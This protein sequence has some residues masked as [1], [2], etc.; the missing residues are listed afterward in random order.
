MSSSK[1][2]TLLTY[3]ATIFLDTQQEF[4]K[5]AKLETKDKTPLAIV[6]SI[7]G[8][9]VKITPQSIS[10]VFE[11]DDLAGKTSFPKTEYQ[12]DFIERGYEDEMKKDTLQKGS[13]HL[14]QGFYFIPFSCVSQTRPLLSMKSH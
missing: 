4:W 6:S 12:T 13:F 3:D 9:S 1:Y 7:K 5:N 14:Q 8:V 11:L 10:E 2:K